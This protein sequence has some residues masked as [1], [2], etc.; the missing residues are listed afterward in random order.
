MEEAD[1][2]SFLELS[3]EGPWAGLKIQ[4]DTGYLH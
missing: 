1:M 4:G 3:G 2:A